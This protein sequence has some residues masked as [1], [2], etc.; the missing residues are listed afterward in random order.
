MTHYYLSADSDNIDIDIEQFDK[1]LMGEKLLV[2]YS[3]SVD[4]HSNVSHSFL[5]CSEID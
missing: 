1:F 5:F 3:V 2:V 4:A